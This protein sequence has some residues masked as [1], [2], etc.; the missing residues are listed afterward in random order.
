MLVGWKFSYSLL[1]QQ[2]QLMPI[3]QSTGLAGL[4]GSV[5]VINPGEISN[6]PPF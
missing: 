6:G 3:E 5:S 1:G 4:K 2:V